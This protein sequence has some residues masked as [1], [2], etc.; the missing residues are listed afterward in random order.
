M[1]TIGLAVTGLGAL[2]SAGGVIG[3]VGTLLSAGIGVVS[4][5]NQSQAQ[6]QQAELARISAQS[7]MITAEME[8]VRGQQEANRIREATLKTLASQRARYAS[9]GIVL[10]S[11]TPATVAEDTTDTADR[12]TAVVT[13][14]AGMRA[15][16]Q[17]IVALNQMARAEML[18]EQSDWT[19]I[20]GVGS[21]VL[22]ADAGIGRLAAT[23]PGSQK[24]GDKIIQ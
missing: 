17:R 5:I 23:L 21:A 14:N 1:E 22:K 15:A 20:G 18:E 6:A 12:E 19:L 8:I 11:G 24:L 7:G 13:T 4:A 3:T 10:D 9:A 2:G 16:S